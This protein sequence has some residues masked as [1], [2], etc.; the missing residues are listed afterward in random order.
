MNILAQLA[1]FL[2]LWLIAPEYIEQKDDCES[3]L[4]VRPESKS[5]Y[6]F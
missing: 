2:C 5:S 6:G 4:Q 1:M 3:L